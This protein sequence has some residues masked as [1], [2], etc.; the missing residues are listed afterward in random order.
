MHP[1]SLANYKLQVYNPGSPDPHPKSDLL[2]NFSREINSD[3]GN[4]L[5]LHT[6]RKRKTVSLKSVPKIY[7]K[8]HK[9]LK[10]MRGN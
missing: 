9:E 8:K 3:P 4:P 7:Q 10:E 2:R 5:I 1:E 6:K